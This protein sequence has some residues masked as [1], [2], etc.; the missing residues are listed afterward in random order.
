MNN[1]TD[2]ANIGDFE[3]FCQV[4]VSFLN[5]WAEHMR[6]LRAEIYSGH[7]DKAAEQVHSLHK[8]LCHLNC[9]DDLVRTLLDFEQDLVQRDRK[10]AK[11]TLFTVSKQVRKFAE[12]LELSLT[13]YEEC[14]GF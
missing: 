12:S 8:T 4:S 9:P 3:L 1:P 5:A 10:Q 11:K 7:L 2:E 13:R 14:I 6:Q